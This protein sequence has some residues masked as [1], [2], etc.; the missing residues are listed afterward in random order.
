MAFIV[1]LIVLIPQLVHLEEQ[2]FRF[3]K[4]SRKARII[5]S[6]IF[7]LFHGFVGVNLMG[8]ILLMVFGYFLSK[9]YV[10]S[11]HKAIAESDI[12]NFE[13]DTEFHK[14]ALFSSTVYHACWNTL[15]LTFILLCLLYTLGVHIYYIYF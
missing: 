10:I 14:K 8:M 3:K 15:I 13:D 9:V 12:D 2:I 1:F 7:G 5:S 4:L 11:Y 6:A